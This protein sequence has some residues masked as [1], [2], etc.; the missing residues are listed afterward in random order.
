MPDP[1]RPELE[2]IG[3]WPPSKT[4]TRLGSVYATAEFVAEA[5]RRIYKEQMA[6]TEGQSLRKGWWRGTA[7]ASARSMASHCTRLDCHSSGNCG[8]GFCCTFHRRTP[9]GRKWYFRRSETYSGAATLH[10]LKK[11][12]PPPRYLGQVMIAAA[13]LTWAAIGWQTWLAFH[14]PTQGYTQAQLDKAVDE[15]KAKA[16]RDAPKSAPIVVHE[17]AT[18]QE[19]EKAA[20]PIRQ[21]FN[22]QIVELRSQLDTLSK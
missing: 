8:C 11:K 17:P 3:D 19:V 1:K 22:R 2:P 16:L 5:V 12:P 7:N 18:P 14:S 13:V 9:L 10:L 15:A 20:A 6:V 4:A 21:Q